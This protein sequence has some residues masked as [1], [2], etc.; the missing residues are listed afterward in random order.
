M[1]I[2]ALRTKDQNAK[3]WAMLGDIATQHEH[4][5]AGQLSPEA[6]KSLAMEQLGH[7]QA[8]WMMSLDEKRVVPVHEGRSSRLT[9]ETFSDLI[10][11]ITAYGAENNVE[12]SD[13]E[14][15]SQMAAARRE[16]A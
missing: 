1:T 11:L 14:W 4:P 12:W 15:V 8:R 16:A 13:P 2:G 9:K 10:E 6:W 3:M 5:H 7:E